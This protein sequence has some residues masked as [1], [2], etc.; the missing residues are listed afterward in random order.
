MFEGSSAQRRLVPA[1][2]RGD[3]QLIAA[4]SNLSEQGKDR[5]RRGEGTDNRF[6]ISEPEQS[7]SVKKC[8]KSDPKICQKNSDLWRNS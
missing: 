4:A 5:G 2:Q 6:Q 3:L 7:Q 8:E 1:C